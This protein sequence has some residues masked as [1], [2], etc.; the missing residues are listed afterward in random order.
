MSGQGPPINSGM[1]IE[2]I[3]T[4][5]YPLPEDSLKELKTH[6]SEIEL[7]KG[8]II[9]RA[10]RVE[11]YVFFI[12]RGIARAFASFEDRDV[13]FW[14]GKEGDAVLSMRSYV[15]AAPAY[16]NV[17]LLETSQLYQLEIQGLEDLYARDVHIANW[18]R[19]LAEK[20]LLTLES[21]IVSTEL[22]N[23]RQRYQRLVRKHPELL[24]RVP[25]KYI[26][27]YLGI[28]QVSLSRIRK[29]W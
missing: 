26:A 7:P 24:Q 3:L 8:H 18:G 9:L 23:A 1:Q 4:R 6:I 19:K 2:E 15:E 16:E 10:N 13:T 20:E 21:R 12:R 5:I 28:T 29:S 25:L 11:R 17:E 22:L 14:F 27:S